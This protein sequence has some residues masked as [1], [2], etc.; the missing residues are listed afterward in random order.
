MPKSS[1]LLRQEQSIKESV[2]EEFNNAKE[3]IKYIQE[4][5]K[6]LIRYEHDWNDPL[7]AKL[8]EREVHAKE[9]ELI[10]QYLSHWESQVTQHRMGI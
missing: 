8:V 3:L 9:C 10:H 2:I 7:I 4:L 5:Q 6:A 1:E